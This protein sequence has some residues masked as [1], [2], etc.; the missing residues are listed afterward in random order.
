M[1]ET[2]E[3]SS[4]ERI[5]EKMKDDAAIEAALKRA[6]YKAVLRHRQGGVPMSFWENGKVVE[7]SAFDVPIPSDKK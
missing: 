7:V 2:I 4:T 3:Q 5:A 6:F 1:P